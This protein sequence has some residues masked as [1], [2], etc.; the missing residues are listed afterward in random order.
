MCVCVRLCVLCVCACVSACVC[1]CVHVCVYVCMCVSI[2]VCVATDKEDR[3]KNAGLIIGESN[4]WRGIHIYIYVCV[5]VCG[6][7]HATEL[8]SG[9]YMYL[10]VYIILCIDTIGQV[11]IALLHF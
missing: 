4:W 6:G 1:P 8:A 11:F 10:E 2:T 7:M 9:L 3:S 5:C